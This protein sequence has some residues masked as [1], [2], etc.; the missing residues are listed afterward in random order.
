MN[1]DATKNDIP[2]EEL[3]RGIPM[4]IPNECPRRFTTGFL[5]VFL[6]VFMVQGSAW[7][8]SRLSISSMS[9]TAHAENW[10]NSAECPSNI[11][12]SQLVASGRSAVTAAC[13]SGANKDCNSK[14][15]TVRCNALVGMGG[16]PATASL[17][18]EWVSSS[19]WGQRISC[20]DGK[21]ITSICGSGANP[22][23][24]GKTAAIQCSRIAVAM[25]GFGSGGWQGMNTTTKNSTWSSTANW[26]GTVTCP[27]GKVATG[28]CGSGGNK[29]CQGNVIELRCSHIDFK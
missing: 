4:S 16:G 14:V 11:A 23:C 6:S 28:F 2:Q 9:A 18:V 22:D 20:P 7:A 3:P 5:A 29:D 19:N 17:D 13:G 27:P 26:G 24:S 15:V 10:G 1:L 21:V 8:D 25:P 12:S